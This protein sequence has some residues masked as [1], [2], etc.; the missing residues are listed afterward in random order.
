[1]GHVSFWSILLLLIS[2]GNGYTTKKNTDAR[3]EI[4]ARPE[5]GLEANI[6]QTN[7]ILMYHR[8]NAHKYHNKIMARHFFNVQITGKCVKKSKFYQ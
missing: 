5:V 7:D 8:L 4:N 3:I 1:M 6:E 2:S